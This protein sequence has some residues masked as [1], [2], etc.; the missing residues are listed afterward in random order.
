MFTKACFTNSDN[1]NLCPKELSLLYLV[2]SQNQLPR[3]CTCIF[4]VIMSRMSLSVCAASADLQLAGIAPSIHLEWGIRVSSAVGEREMRSPRIP[5]QRRLNCGA[6][7]VCVCMCV[8]IIRAFGA[9]DCA[10]SLCEPRAPSLSLSLVLIVC[11]CCLVILHFAWMAAPAVIN[12]A[13]T[14]WH[15][16]TAQTLSSNEKLFFFPRRV[17][18]QLFT[19]W[20]RR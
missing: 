17:S 20:E 8:I 2:F 9:R 12:F 14:P 11:C 16:L 6:L 1:F 18:C 3:L 19:L 13:H 10:G 5:K 4:L 15:Q 7:C